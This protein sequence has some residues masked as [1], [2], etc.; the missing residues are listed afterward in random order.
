MTQNKNMFSQGFET[1]I[2]CRWMALFYVVAICTTGVL[3]TLGIGGTGLSVGEGILETTLTYSLCL[4]LLNLDPKSDNA[5]KSFGGFLLRDVF[6][7]LVPLVVLGFGISFA[8]LS[9]FPGE[10]SKEGL[11][12]GIVLPL[13]GV[14][15]LTLMFLFGTALPSKLIGI[16]ASV[17]TAVS[18]AFRQFG[19]FL[20][21]LV[22][23]VGA[24]GLLSYVVLFGAESV[25]LSSD[26]VSTTGDVN[27]GGAAV[28]VLGK[29]LSTVSTALFAVAICS[30]YL[31]DLRERGEFPPGEAEVFA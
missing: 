29:F 22:M 9:A 31:K 10:A 20:P 26:P 5:R 14:A 19:F 7:I 27:P 28:F 4:H 15:Y 11:I 30:T 17:G 12:I 16:E 8:V 1:L 13:V 24:I 2:A 21:R 23:G 25:G 3:K 6:L 18:R